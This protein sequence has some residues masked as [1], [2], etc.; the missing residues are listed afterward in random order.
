MKFLSGLL[1]AS[2]I[3]AQ[4]PLNVKL[5]GGGRVKLGEKTF[6]LRDASESKAYVPLSAE[7][8]KAGF[9]KYYVLAYSRYEYTKRGAEHRDRF[10]HE[11]SWHLCLQDQYLIHSFMNTETATAETEFPVFKTIDG[12]PLR[13]DLFSDNVDIKKDDMAYIYSDDMSNLQFSRSE[14]KCKGDSSL[15]IM[16]S[17]FDQLS[18]V[19]DVNG[20]TIDIIIDEKTDSNAVSCENCMQK[21]EDE[22]DEVAS[23]KKRISELEEELGTCKQDNSVDD[24]AC[25]SCEEDLAQCKADIKEADKKFEDCDE[26]RKDCEKNIEDCIDE[27][28]SCNKSLTECNDDAE[29][30]GIPPGFDAIKRDENY[31]ENWNSWYYDLISSPD[32]PGVVFVRIPKFSIQLGSLNEAIKKCR[33]MGMVLATVRSYEEDRLIHDWYL[34]YQHPDPALKPNYPNFPDRSTYGSVTAGYKWAGSMQWYWKLDKEDA[35]AGKYG[36]WG[37]E[38]YADHKYPI[39]RRGWP[40]IPTQCYYV[41]GHASRT[42]ETSVCNAAG[43]TKNYAQIVYYNTNGWGSSVVHKWD[44]LCEYRN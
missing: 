12:A 31:A 30:D 20:V 35:A 17:V 23:L 39:D 11:D 22:Q 6:L 26:N 2:P 7:M 4:K 37:K 1:L 29:D 15:W 27:K 19:I 36:E 10:L 43:G 21:L 18:K 41:G 32:V 8:M 28:E 14:I 13:V 34:R 42:D 40:N 5:P 24:S 33:M 3:L 9:W 16:K 25:D 38:N 44:H